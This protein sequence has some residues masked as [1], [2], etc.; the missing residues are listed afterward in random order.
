MI[1]CCKTKFIFSTWIFFTR[2]YFLLKKKQKQVIFFFFFF[3]GGG[4]GSEGPRFRV[5]GKKGI[6]LDEK[7]W[8]IGLFLQLLFREKQ[9]FYIFSNLKKNGCEKRLI[10]PLALKQCFG[11][12]LPP[13][14]QKIPTGKAVNIRGVP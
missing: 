10:L 3:W 2:I 9:F 8:K 7:N 1:S 11:R 12:I 4:G 5:R 6:F 13:P 14:P